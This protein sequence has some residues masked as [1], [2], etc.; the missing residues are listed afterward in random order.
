MDNFIIDNGELKRS[1]T[2]TFS[3]AHA[4]KVIQVNEVKIVKLVIL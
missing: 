4:I 1:Q 2:K 3:K